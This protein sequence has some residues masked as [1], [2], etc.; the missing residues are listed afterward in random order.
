MFFRQRDAANAT[1]SYL[2]GCGGL[3]KAIAGAGLSGKP[4]STIGFERRFNPLL[5][6]SRDAFVDAL[7]ASI[8]PW[9][10]EMRTIVRDNLGQAR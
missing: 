1:L 8:P 9:P 4:G 7:V 10:A 2:F 3:G 5:S 6:M